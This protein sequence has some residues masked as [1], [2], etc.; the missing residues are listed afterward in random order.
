MKKDMNGRDSDLISS[1]GARRRASCKLCMYKR[2]MGLFSRQ[3]E[4]LLAPTFR[5]ASV[6][7]QLELCLWRRALDTNDSIDIKTFDLLH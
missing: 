7:L 6:T 4:K 3:S 5:R 1:R 2:S